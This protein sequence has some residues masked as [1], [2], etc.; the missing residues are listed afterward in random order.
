MCVA[1]LR[2]DL[3]RS[4]DLETAREGLENTGTSRESESSPSSPLASG[5]AR[6]LQAEA[7]DLMFVDALPRL[8][9][10]LLFEHG[11]HTETFIGVGWFRLQKEERMATSASSSEARG[12]RHQAGVREHA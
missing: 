3:E 7:T 6:S 11:L 5:S 10:K 1:H 12:V 9:P 2:N 4:Q 8:M